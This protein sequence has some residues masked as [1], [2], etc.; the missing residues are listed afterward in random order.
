MTGRKLSE[1]IAVVS[2]GCLLPDA[3]NPEEFWKNVLNKKVSIEKAKDGRFDKEVHFRPEMYGKTQK[4]DKTYT[5]LGS[6]T[7]AFEFNGARFRLPPTVTQHM[8]SNQKVMVLSTEQALSHVNQELWNREKVSVF[9]GSTFIGELHHD[10]QRRTHFDRFQYHLQKHPDFESLDTEKRQ[11]VLQDL[12]KRFLDGTV[13]ISEDTAPGVLPNIIAARINSVFDFHGHAY[14]IDAACASTLAAIIDGVQHLESGE[15]DVA[16][17][18]GADLLNA[19][20]GRIYFSGI[21]ALSPDGS[22]PF[23]ERANGFVIGEGGGVF[24]LKRFSDAICDKDTILALISGYGQNSDGKGKAIAAPNSKWQAKAIQDALEMAQFHP[25]TIELIEAHGTSTKV[26]DKSEIDALNMCFKKLGATKKGYCAV[27][28][29]KSNV[30]H[31]KAAAGVPGFMKTVQALQYKILP[32]T[33]NCQKVSPALALE[34][35]PF[36]INT[37]KQDWLQ[38]DHSRRAGVSAFGFGGANYHITLEEFRKEDV[39]KKLRDIESRKTYFPVSNASK[40]ASMRV[41]E[42]ASENAESTTVVHETLALFFSANSRKDLTENLHQLQRRIAEG[43][44]EQEN[45]RELVLSQNYLAK[46]TDVH[47]LAITFQGRVDLKTKITT[48][49]QILTETPADKD[50]AKWSLMAQK[51]VFYGNT[52]PVKEHE[53]AFLFPGQASQYPDM[54]LEL[55]RYYPQCSA[56]T[57]PMDAFWSANCGSRISDLISSKQRGEEETT[58]LLKN[59]RNTHPALLYGSILCNDILRQH[60]VTAS[61]MAGHSAGEISALLAGGYLDLENALKLMD[62]R[63]RR[64]VEMGPNQDDGTVDFGKMAAVKTTREKL[65]ALLAQSQTNVVLANLNSP[66]QLI[67]SGFTSDMDAFLSFLDTQKVRYVVLNVSHAFHSPVVRPAAEQY[68][69][70]LSNVT[71]SQGKVPVF[72]NQTCEFYSNDDAEIRDTLFKQITGPV[73]FMGSI[74]KMAAQGVRLFVEVGPNQVL[75]Q[76]TRATLKGR[77]V[78]VI[79][80][81][82]QKKSDLDGIQCCLGACFA[83]GVPVQYVPPLTMTSARPPKTM[84]QPSISKSVSQTMAPAIVYSGVSVGLPGSY[85]KSFRDDNFNQLFEGHNFIEALTVTDKSRLASLNVSKVEKTAQGPVF[86]LLNTIG[87]VI[88]LAGKMG[89]IDALRDYRI[90]EDE[91]SQMNQA[92][93]HAVAAGFEALRDARIP[94]IHHYTKTSSGGLLP[95][96]WVIPKE[97][98]RRTGV[99]FA[100]G[101][102]MV[103]TVLAEV[104]RHLNHK[105]AGAGKTKQMAFYHQLLPLIQDDKAKN[106]LTDWFI[107][108]QSTLQLAKTDEAIF[109]FNHQFINQISALANNRLAQYVQALGPNFQINA[110]CSSTCTAVTLSQ[111]MIAS[112]RVDRMLILGADDATSELSLPYLGAG[113][114]STG[115]ASCESDVRD[116]A[117]PF[118]QRRNGMIMSAGAVA[119]VIER[120]DEVQ[121]RGVRPV[122][123]LLGSHVFNTAGHHAR[124][125]VPM[126]ADELK[127]FLDEMAQ[128]YQ[129]DLKALSSDLIYV[130]HETYTP[131]RGGCSE[132]EAVSLRHVFGDDYR[133]VLVTNTKGMTGH[134][135]GASIEDVVAARALES[136]R[137]PPVVNF[138]VPD[139]KLAGLK[140]SAGGPHECH[141]ALR[142]AAGFGS[143]GNYILLRKFGDAVIDATA[144]N[145]LDA[146]NDK[147]ID[148]PERYFQ[149]LRM[150]SGDENAAL[151][152]E[153]RLLRI[154]DNRPGAIVNTTGIDV[155]QSPSRPSPLSQA[156]DTSESTR[157]QSPPLVTLQITDNASTP[158][159]RNQLQEMVFSVVSDITGYAPEMLEADMEVE[160][161]L[162]IDTVKQATILSMIGEKL[163]V[164]DE[165]EFQIA[166]YPTLASWI[167]LFAGLSGASVSQK[168]NA[169][170]KAMGIAS[171]DEAV[172]AQVAVINTFPVSN[173]PSAS[174][175]SM[176]AVNTSV[177]KRISQLVF[178][179]VSEIT[180]YAPEMLEADMEVENDLGIDTV[181]QATILSTLSETLGIAEEIEFQIAAYPTL[182]SWIS[183]FEGF[184]NEGAPSTSKDMPDAPEATNTGAPDLSTASAESQ[185]PLLRHFIVRE[186]ASNIM[187]KSGEAPRQLTGNKLVVIGE[188]AEDFKKWTAVLSNRCSE[189]IL[190]DISSTALTN[191][192]ETLKRKTLDAAQDTTWLDISAMKPAQDISRQLECRFEFAK[193]AADFKP[194]AILSLGYRTA[195]HGA[196]TGFYQALSKEWDMPYWAVMTSESDC[197]ITQRLVDTAIEV[198]AAQPE[199]AMLELYDEKLTF[200]KVVSSAEIASQQIVGGATQ[201]GI[202]SWESSDVLLVTGATG[203]T[204][205]TAVAFA[206]KYPCKIALMGRTVLCDE[207]YLS[208][209]WDEP[210]HALR[211]AEIYQRLK[212]ELGRVRPV[213]VE[214][215]FLHA[216]K[217][218][219]LQQNIQILKDA[220]AEV[221]YLNCDVTHSHD[222]KSALD[223]VK[224][225]WGDITGI[226]HGAGVENSAMLDKKTKSEF[227]RVVT[228]KVVGAQN[229]LSHIALEK[230]KLWICFS[231]ISGIFGNAA[232]TDYS[233]A[234]AYL[235]F[236]TL[237]LQQQHP[238]LLA[239]SIAWSGWAKTGMAWRNSYVRENA[240]KIGLHF[241]LPSQGTSVAVSLMT[242]NDGPSVQVIHQGLGDMLDAKWRCQN[243]FPKPVV[244][245]VEKTQSGHRFFKTLDV[246]HDEWLNQHRL[247]DTPLLPGVGYLEM[248]AEIHCW[249]YPFGN[250]ICYNNL[251]FNDAFKLSCEKPRDIFIDVAS[252]MDANDPFTPVPMKIYSEITGRLFSETREYCSADVSGLPE[253]APSFESVWTEPGWT[254]SGDHFSVF[255]GIEQLPQNVIFGNLFHDFKRE[256]A[257]TTGLKYQW[258]D[259][260]LMRDYG[261]P[262]EQLTHPKYPLDKLIINFCLMDSIHQAGVVHTV[263]KTGK[264]HLPCGARKFAIYNKCDSPVR[265]KNYVR[266]VSQQ[267]DRFVYDIFLLNDKNEIC[268]IAYECEFRK[269]V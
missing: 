84:P 232:Q 91:V 249:K 266:L 113:F 152:L 133:N 14:T 83:A 90:D 145:P 51:G 115:A 140:L 70:D 26:G 180:G 15:S 6:S 44:F 94:L 248:M 121:K 168:T 171:S 222:V 182:A 16:I 212:N 31:L 74:E 128:Q 72:A 71:F 17:C 246:R 81:N 221:M 174:P 165:F 92:I 9:V 206:K 238:T 63:S 215:A 38:K 242:Q 228:P 47:R 185:K 252:A 268:A 229:L 256:G 253:P 263:I 164:A 237:E 151:E 64:F 107:E 205:R 43:S 86:H 135:M 56:V 100:H 207:N 235:N 161:D 5:E 198:C 192:L 67:V 12:K 42:S 188:A 259:V 243:S 39:T 40:M 68:Q 158:L 226:L 119:I 134:T 130:S 240:E 28:S 186:P 191:T 172:Q 250:G 73:N 124:L 144:Q 137:I 52:P 132:A 76:L 230:L 201:A 258:S 196:L 257:D 106:V 225:N 265:Y 239:R 202:P 179:T 244:D 251:T 55:N 175:V 89:Q 102:P 231:S 98:Q 190:A 129:L 45:A 177:R 13:M 187:E 269:I 49:L 234:N 141:F 217:Q 29:A 241:I 69:R 223:K 176:A 41:D 153:G 34:E 125:N 23:D 93:L 131:A 150:V 154:K 30:G 122:C 193:A 233:A 166:A 183:L 20:L 123:E 11:N 36:Y 143:Q 105:F 127:V 87:D 220:G 53:I 184:A 104:T 25:H 75:T 170:S 136:G 163:K 209:D 204:A 103:E 224:N 146:G 216:L 7:P 82:P 120:L 54:C 96:R 2:M 4:F 126:Y 214:N 138:K 60:G 95:D 19:E 50:T 208:N 194:N 97:M 245:R 159:S 112:G 65:D 77:D 247:L 169:P 101:F 157:P 118:D 78:S 111:D 200:W 88:Q 167:D 61:R 260:A 181:K 156:P 178:E 189:V 80:T 219:E 195:L 46:A 255:A 197:D 203:I 117:L 79:P 148:D 1:Q 58:A 116:A 57:G 32:P 27:G 21:N 173:V 199:A 33:A 147:R 142:M 3:R 85:K 24:I 210:N 267:T 155:R 236:I 160:N 37:E 211:K 162:G 254:H 35:S 22:Y 62:Y 59:T 110:A 227:L 264:V 262:M 18:G 109:R 114:L 48:V 218:R 261:F 139:P 149:W 8:D 213:D 66:K 108:N 10:F 99:I